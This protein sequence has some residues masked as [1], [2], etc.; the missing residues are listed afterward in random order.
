MSK[1]TLE[2]HEMHRFL[3]RLRIL[4]SLETFEVDPDGKIREGAVAFVQ[5][6]VRTVLRMDETRQ[7]MVWAALR[8][9]EDRK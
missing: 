1:H 9:R 3:N 7:A 4:R 8:K 6:P 2:R 5:D